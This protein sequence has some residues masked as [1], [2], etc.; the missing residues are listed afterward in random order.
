MAIILHAYQEPVVNLSRFDGDWAWLLRAIMRVVGAR[1][2]HADIA[3]GNLYEQTRMSWEPRVYLEMPRPY[4]PRERAL[5]LSTD[6]TTAGMWK[7]RLLRRT[8]AESRPAM[9]ARCRCNA[10]RKDRPGSAP[11]TR[12]TGS[13]LGLAQR[14]L[15]MTRPMRKKA[16]TMTTATR[17]SLSTMRSDVIIRIPMMNMNAAIT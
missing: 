11:R 16:S 12:V 6:P 1:H 2:F 17:A 8:Q 4:I 14:H 5:L 7:P 15:R 13:K 3:S 9:Q 10:G